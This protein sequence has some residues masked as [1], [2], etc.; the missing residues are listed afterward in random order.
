MTTVD[1][2]MLFC[3][4]PFVVQFD[5]SVPHQLTNRVDP[6]RYSQTIQ[7]ANQ[8]YSDYSYRWVSLIYLIVAIGLIVTMAVLT[9]RIDIPIFTIPAVYVAI[10]FPFLMFEIYKRRKL[11]SALGVFF[12]TENLQYQQNGLSFI[13]H[14]HAFCGDS[15]IQV[16]DHGLG[17][18]AQQTSY[19]SPPYGIPFQQQQQGPYGYTNTY[20]VPNTNPYNQQVTPLVSQPYPK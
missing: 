20:L 7:G 10:T 16:I 19:N 11:Y 18:Y 9:I 1:V 14:S 13:Y 12:A 2:P 6:Y 15:L 4:T 5:T 17:H 3:S 8:I